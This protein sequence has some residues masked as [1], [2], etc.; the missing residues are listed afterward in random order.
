M[1]YSFKGDTHIKVSL[2]ISQD[3]QSVA[4]SINSGIKKIQ[5]LSHLHEITEL[6]MAKHNILESNLDLGLW[7]VPILVCDVRLKLKVMRHG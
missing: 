5:I 1:V 3:V 7:D 2:T 4:F 6:R